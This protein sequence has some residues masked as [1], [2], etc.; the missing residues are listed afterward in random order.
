[1]IKVT[2]LIKI[3][4][5]NGTNFFTGVPDSVLKELSLY[6]GKNKSNHIL[7]TNEGSAVSIGIGYYLST[8]K[9]LVFTCKIQVYLMHLILLFL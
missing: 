6:L 5:K 9:F 2:S 8:K 4:K 7:A 1:M 3:L